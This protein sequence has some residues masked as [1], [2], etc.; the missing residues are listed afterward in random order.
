MFHQPINFGDILLGRWTSLVALAPIFGNTVRS[1]SRGHA[2]RTQHSYH[3][4]IAR[5]GPNQNL[6]MLDRYMG[7]PKGSGWRVALSD[8]FVLDTRDRARIWVGS[9]S[10]RL[11]SGSDLGRI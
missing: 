10:T 11:G 1:L 7:E 2:G 8:A 5:F 6:F 9:G 4:E 3:A